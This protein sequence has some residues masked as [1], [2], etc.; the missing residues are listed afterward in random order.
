MKKIKVLVIVPNYPKD[1]NVVYKFV[2][3]RVKAYVDSNIDVDVFC[4]HKKRKEKY[5]FENINVTV[6]DNL[7]LLDKINNGDYS[8]YAIHFFNRLN[9][10]FV[11]KYL[12]DKKTFIWFHGSDCISW[13]RR[14][15]SINIKNNLDYFNPIKFMKLLLLI[16]IY[17]ERKYLIKKINKNHDLNTFVFVSKWLKEMSEKDYNIKYKNY[18]IIHNYVDNTFFEY[19]KKDHDKR[20]KVLVINNFANDL[21]A[22]DLMNKILLE[23]SKNEIFNN[24]TFEI[25]GDGKK[26]EQSLKG[27]SSYTN[28]KINKGFL[29]QD[30]IKNA[31]LNNGVF[32]YPKRG[33]SQGVSRCEAM[34]S[35]LVTVVSD[36]EAISE[37]GSNDVSYL[38][39]LTN[40]FI[41]AFERIY[42]NKKE[43]MLK[44][45]MSAKFIR[46]K[47]N[48]ENTIQK[49]ID[50]F[51]EEEN[52]K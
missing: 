1:K 34:S 10:R 40:D 41:A 42:L 37:F 18:E 35:G 12:K 38:C 2:H 7:K 20:L 19:N 30:Q 11:L 43:Y 31:H 26:F 29:N 16:I 33:D 13:K 44:S 3:D 21:Y 6:D 14:K 4:L 5:I 36:V 50:M 51:L 25:Y 49:E 9:A 48:Y 27:L 28:I 22:G 52:R 39:N 45:K 8:C 46:E 47:C 32:L 17:S 15:S 24:F 23:F